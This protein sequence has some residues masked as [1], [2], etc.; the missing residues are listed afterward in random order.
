MLVS[1]FVCV[2]VLCLCFVCFC[3]RVQFSSLLFFVF[4]LFDSLV[5][6]FWNSSIGACSL[7]SWSF[8]EGFSVSMSLNLFSVY[9]IFVVDLACWMSFLYSSSYVRIYN[10]ASSLGMFWI[11]SLM[12]FLSGDFISLALLFEFQNVPLFLLLNTRFYLPVD[13]QS[14]LNKGI[15]LAVVLLFVFG[16][17]SGVL[18]FLACVWLVW[19]TNQ[20]SVNLSISLFEG[21]SLASL[22]KF[23]SVFLLLLIGGAIKLAL[24]PFHVWLG[25]VH[26]EASTVG[27]IVLASVALK[28]GFY[29]HCI[30]WKMKG[31]SVLEGWCG[32]VLISLLVG[33]VW[34][35]W[36]LFFQVDIKRWVALFSISHMNIFYVLF[37]VCVVEGGHW[38]LSSNFM[39]VLMFGMVAHS[40]VSA[41]MFLCAG[42]L[43]DKMGTRYLFEI[44]SKGVSSWWYSAMFCFIVV[45]GGFPG[46]MLFYY[47]IVSFSILSN[48]SLVLCIFCLLCS[49]SC[50]ISGLLCLVKYFSNLV[51]CQTSPVNEGAIVLW[52]SGGLLLVLCGSGLGLVLLIPWCV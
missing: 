15:G 31:F 43:S 14:N 32:V 30:L 38:N 40:F 27:S 6:L 48:W 17:V 21:S 34:S 24:F 39:G 28:T 35:T 3:I 37:L 49:A 36:S 29:I 7:F 44:A 50:L 51:L 5:L 12:F 46:W 13:V 52:L 9:M 45:N 19:F 18:L 33:C 22:E 47:E 42:W 16:L 23:S 25:K 2:K 41:G 11:V 10:E 8:F 26:V 20:C 1:S 4:V